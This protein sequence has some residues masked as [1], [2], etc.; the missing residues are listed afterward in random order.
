MS[1]SKNTAVYPE[2]K[3][4]IRL[5]LTPW[6]AYLDPYSKYQFVRSLNQPA[7][8][9]LDIGCG[10]DSVRKLKALAPLAQFDGIDIEEYQMSEA[11]KRAMRTYSIVPK[12]DFFRHIEEGP[13]YDGMV[14]SHVIEH[15]EEPNRFLE[16]LLSKLKSGGK[17][18]VSTPCMKSVNFPALKRGCL[19]FYDDPTHLLNIVHEDDKEAATHLLTSH[20]PSDSV[21][22]RWLNRDGTYRWASASSFPIFETDGDAQINRPSLI[23]IVVQDVD[24]HAAHSPGPDRLGEGLLV[25]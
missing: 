11:G 18:Y 21:E 19:N 5:W 2:F 14:L 6:K 3:A 7:A 13:T 10:V 1:V 23:Q 16:M 8:E 20:V 25:Y 17:L 9:I 12:E 15:L 22:Y 4:S 24:T